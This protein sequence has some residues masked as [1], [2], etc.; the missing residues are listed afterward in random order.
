MHYKETVFGS[1]IEQTDIDK[2][3]EALKLEWLGQGSYTG[4]FESKIQ[5]H[6]Q[7]PDRYFVAVSTGYAAIHLALVLAGVKEGD[8]VITPS[9]NNIADFQAIE[10]TGAD[11][12]FCD[13]RDDNFCIDLDKAEQLITSKTKAIIIIDYACWQPDYEKAEYIAKKYNLRIIH[14]AC[15]SFGWKYKGKMSGSFSD[16]TA[17]SFDPVKTITCIDGGA[18]IV[19]TKEEQKLAQELRILGMTQPAQVNYQ[20]RRAW[21]YDSVREGFRYHFANIHAALGIAQLEKIDRIAAIQRSLF[22]LYT[23]ELSGIEEMRIPHCNLDDIIPL[24]Y[25]PRLPK[26]RRNEFRKMMQEQGFETGTHWKPGHLFSYFSDRKQGD[27]TVVNNIYEE[28][29]SLPFHCRVK[30]ESI[31]EIGALCKK[32]FSQQVFTGIQLTGNQPQL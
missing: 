9:L 11:I 12:V 10:H 16:L 8:E 18:I 4:Q 26:D 2:I 29:I 6:C 19:K 14:D 20:N 13:S 21:E 5:E 32:F 1:F 3:T 27:L 17:F 31:K 23:Q 7:A 22:E 28:F 30:P 25:V 15:H 24:L